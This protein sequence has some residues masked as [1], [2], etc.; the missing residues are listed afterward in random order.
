MSAVT[1]LFE[2][3]KGT[4]PVTPRGLVGMHQFSMLIEEKATV[5]LARLSLGGRHAESGKVNEMF[6]RH[7]SVC[8]PS[9]R[10]RRCLFTG[11][12]ANH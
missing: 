4:L 11:P 9:D 10:L 2:C 8:M 6:T 12:I 3:C 7:Q 1:L 5:W